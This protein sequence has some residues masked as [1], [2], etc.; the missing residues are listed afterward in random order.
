MRSCKR[1]K[2]KAVSGLKCQICASVYHP[3][4]AKLNHNIKYI[5]D[6]IIDKISINSEHKVR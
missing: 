4:C 1:C 2:N 6:D 3:S 5:S